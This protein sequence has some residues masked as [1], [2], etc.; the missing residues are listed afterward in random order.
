MLREAIGSVRSCAP[1]TQIT[2]K[3]GLVAQA[4]AIL[5][6]NRPRLKVSIVRA[7]GEDLEV[8]QIECFGGQL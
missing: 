1:V 5:K 6:L 4:S 3:I 7:P 8:T 2:A